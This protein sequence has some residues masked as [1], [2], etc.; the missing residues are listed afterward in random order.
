M[1][2]SDKDVTVFFH[3]NVA[4]SDLAAD[5]AA[6]F[7]C[8][9]AEPQVRPLIDCKPMPVHDALNRQVTLFTEQGWFQ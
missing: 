3:P 8:E 4:D 1:A 7:T 2:H 5:T 6:S 9:F